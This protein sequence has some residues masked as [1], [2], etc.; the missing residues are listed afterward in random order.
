ME[1]VKVTNLV[2]F[3]TILLLN[4]GPMH[5]YE[6]IKELEECMVKRISASHVYP[7]LKILEKNKLII[8][9]KA[10]KREKKEYVLTK[11]GKKF[12]D[13]MT[14]RFS[15]MVD[16]SVAKKI[17]KCAHCNCQVYEGGHKEKIK[18]KMLYFCCVHCAKSFN[19]NN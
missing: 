4:K 18:G 13:N 7:F 5:G 15:M 1:N 19:K 16:A 2:K 9:K 17:R 11:E 14:S 3:Y 8:L 10:G 6:L 12:V